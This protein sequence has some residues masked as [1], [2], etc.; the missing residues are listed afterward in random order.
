M[1]LQKTGFITSIKVGQPIQQDHVLATLSFVIFPP[2]VSNMSIRGARSSCGHAVRT[3]TEVDLVITESK[4][5]L[6][7]HV[8]VFVLCILYYILFLF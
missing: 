8:T 5:S 6:S 7:L 2:E 3:P 1:K 4:H